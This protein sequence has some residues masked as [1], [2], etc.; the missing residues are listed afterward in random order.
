MINIDD[1]FFTS[2]NVNWTGLS[3][4]INQSDNCSIVQC[5]EKNLLFFNTTA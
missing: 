3:E 4:D 1:I 5:K 2:E